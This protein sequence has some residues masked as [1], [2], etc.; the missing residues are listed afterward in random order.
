MSAEFLAELATLTDPAGILT[1]A[2]TD[3]YLLDQRR[4]FAGRALAVARPRDTA[5]VAAMLALCHRH[6]VAVVPQG[7]NTSLCGGATPDSSG[8]ALLLSLERFHGIDD[9]D[10]DNNTIT[11]A[12][13]ATL[14]SVQ[15]AARSAGRLFPADWAAA[16]SCQIGGALATNAGG[17]NVLRYGNM[18]NLVLGLEVVL[19]DGTIW[20]GLRGLRKDNTGYDL[21]QLFVG[22][23]GTLGIITRAVLRLYPAPT[24]HATALVPVAGPQAALE[25]LHELQAAAG[26]RITSFEL[27][28]APCMALLAQHFPALPQ[29]FAPIPDWLVLIELADAGEDSAL[30]DKL[31]EVLFAQGLDEALLAQHA[32]QSRAFWELRESIPEAQRLEGVSIK[33]DIS[34]PL[35]AIPD[36]IEQCGRALLA[37]YPTAQI[38]A[39]GHLGDGNLHYNIF[40]PDHSAGVYAEEEHINAIIYREV[41]ER[42]GSFS[43]EHGIGQLKRGLMQHYRSPV[44]LALMRQIKQALDP[45]NLMN[46]GKFLPD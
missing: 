18:R 22:S 15:A 2:A 5:E 43:A 31:A 46:P 13:G 23:E 19:A 11:V 37:A 35:S 25:L 41:A 34:V 26:D 28:S 21:K 32:S 36:F 38:I 40:L 17:I 29:P 12:A 24:A 44:E 30:Q 1:G 3:G 9:I 27:I 33:H 6:R 14:A 42:R 8:Q 7:G 39:F 20:N 4:R 45:H 16:A 10:A